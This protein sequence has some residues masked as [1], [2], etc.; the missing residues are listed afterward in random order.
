MT[1][2]A[3]LTASAEKVWTVQTPFDAIILVLAV[4]I[5]GLACLEPMG[6]GGSPMICSRTPDMSISG[7]SDVTVE[8]EVESAIGQRV[9]GDS[10]KRGIGGGISRI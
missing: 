6:S 5:R 9:V 10:C 8:V 7:V 1:T 3:V 4:Q 2:S